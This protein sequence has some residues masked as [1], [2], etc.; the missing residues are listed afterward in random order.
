MTEPWG[1]TIAEAGRQLRSGAVKS[2]ALTEACLARIADVE[3]ELNA[4]IT[5][6]AGEA[7]EAAAQADAAFAAGRDAGPLQG[8]PV[9]VKDLCMTAGMRTTAGSAIL[10]DWLPETDATVVGKLKEGGAVI[11]GKLNMHEFAYGTTSSA[12]HFGAVRNPLDLARHPGGSSGGSG[13]AVAAGECFAAIGT[14]TGGSIRIP[15]AMCGVV[16]LMPTYGLVSR[17]GVL[18]LAWSLD[19]VGPLTRTAEDAALF[20]GVIA[21]YDAADPGSAPGAAFAGRVGDTGVRG[22][23]VGVV[24][25]QREAAETGVRR[26][27]DDAVAVIRE[28]GAEVGEVDIPAL[29][30]PW[31]GS[32]IA[33]EAAAYHLEWLQTVPE[34]YTAEV[35]ARLMAGLT[36]PAV[37]YVNDLRLRR[38]FT[39]EVREAMRDF[40]VLVAPTCPR[41][42]CPLDEIGA[43]GFIYSSLTAAWDHT[44]QPVIA[45]PCGPAEDGLPASISFIGRP[46]GEATI[47]GAAHAF[48]RATPW[49]SQRPAL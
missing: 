4:F 8:I 14:D 12:S 3:P 28:L 33:A 34:K 18:P 36:I 1:L 37:D 7:L 29:R 9:G 45:V 2:T 17:A 19:H 22:L 47:C 35:R 48:E 23:R 16:G 39:A 31:G 25:A 46:F 10:E 6:A 27:F 30:E 20:L 44:G 43:T 41:V 49:Q 21:G 38:E 40:D 5:V 13:A 15:A 26:A 24:A 11:L 42:S 32:I